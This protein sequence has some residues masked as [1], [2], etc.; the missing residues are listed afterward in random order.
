MSYQDI[1]EKIKPDLEKIQEYFRDRLIE[2]KG[3]RLNPGLVENI[4]VECFGQQ[5][6]LKQ[7]GVITT[8]S[9]GE[10]LIQLW[11]RSY[12]DSVVRAI[13]REN[14]ALGVK[15]EG[16]CIYL[17]APPLTEE[18]K[19]NLIRILNQKK[20]EVFQRI[21]RIRDKAWKE[22]QEG[23]QK[24][25]IREDDKY[26]GKDKLEELI[27]QSREE[28]AKMAENKKREIEQ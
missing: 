8:P 6:L 25:E 5:L 10:L 15:I 13:K 28:I 11:D 12:L 18:M 9:P 24:G 2:L 7:L 14:L 22:I 21:R 17:S 23:F 1:L 4:K 16:N 27:K 19:Q 3:G 26:R 20:E